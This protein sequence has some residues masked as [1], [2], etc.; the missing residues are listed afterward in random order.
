MDMGTG[1]PGWVGR[2]RPKPIIG[3]VHLLP[4]PGSP[5]WTGL[6]D[7]VIDAAV[8]DAATL[9]EGG[10]DGIIVENYGDTPFFPDRVPAET[11]AAMTAAVIEVQRVATVPIGV[12]VLRNDAAAALAVC[13]ATAASFIRVNVHTGAMITDQG[14]IS[15][16]AHQTLRLR[17]ELGLE[18]AIFADVFVKHATPPAGLTIEDAAR[19]CWERGHA[20]ALIVSGTGTG[21]PTSAED[22]ARVK[23]AVPNAP[24]FIGSGLTLENAH[25]LLR[26]ADGAIVGSSIKAE[27]RA[28][29]PVALE[30]VRA[31]LE[32]IEPLRHEGPAQ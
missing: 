26:L 15:G 11:V 29:S 4:L 20:D 30:R 1:R 18:T 21:Q 23:R 19:D 9:A 27:N 28:D 12:N 2:W 6:M 22:I 17:S 25:E 14:W 24:L 16:A 5:R 10:V 31:L 13:A 3:M 7:Q 8:R 32:I